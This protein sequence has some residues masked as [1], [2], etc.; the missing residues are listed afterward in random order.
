MVIQTF[1]QMKWTDCKMYWLADFRVVGHDPDPSDVAEF[2]NVSE[3][4]SLFISQP[5]VSNWGWRECAIAAHTHGDETTYIPTYMETDDS[6]TGGKL[7]PIHSACLQLIERVCQTRQGLG[8]S[9]SSEHPRT[10]AEFCDALAT[11]KCERRNLGLELPHKYYGTS[12][13]WGQQ[14]QEEAGWEVSLQYPE[15]WTDSPRS[16]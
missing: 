11:K 16:H 1:I 15:H 4:P 5:A 7:L 6:R 2:V 9:S 13:F 12:Q 3:D 14:W 10:L 8:D